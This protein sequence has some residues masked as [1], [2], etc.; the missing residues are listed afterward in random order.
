MA[1]D[2]L[3]IQ[4]PMLAVHVG[5]PELDGRRSKDVHGPVITHQ[6]RVQR[7]AS[8]RRVATFVRGHPAIFPQPA[9]R[10]ISNS[11]LPTQSAL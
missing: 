10:G 4:P 1:I 3:V 5:L 11:Q 7:Y 2:A 6:S 8:P 9:D